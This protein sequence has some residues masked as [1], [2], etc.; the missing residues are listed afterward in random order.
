MNLFSR[1]A[2]LLMHANVLKVN[3]KVQ[4][5]GYNQQF[6]QGNAGLWIETILF[7]IYEFN[8]ANGGI[9]YTVR[10]KIIGTPCH[11]YIFRDNVEVGNTIIISFHKA[12][13]HISN[14]LQ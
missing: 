2:G 12:Y 7:K 4:Y 9:I 3:I 11:I 6:V 1:E 10:D 5:T 14:K 13:N 8:G